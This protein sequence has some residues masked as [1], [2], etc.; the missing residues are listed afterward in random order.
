MPVKFGDLLN[1]LSGELGSCDIYKDVGV[2]PF[3]LDDLG[4]DGRRTGFI[5]RLDDDQLLR[6]IAKPRRL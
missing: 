3:Y 1:G 5:W 6:Q 4:V 2:R